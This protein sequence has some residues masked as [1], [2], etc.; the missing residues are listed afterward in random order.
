MAPSSTERLADTAM[1]DVEH[2]LADSHLRPQYLRYN[3][4][5]YFLKCFAFCC[6]VSFVN[7]VGIPPELMFCS[8]PAA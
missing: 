4:I 1:R 2:E 8:C 5:I 7:A 6:S 3:Y